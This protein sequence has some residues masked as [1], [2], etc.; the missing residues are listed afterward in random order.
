MNRMVVGLLF[1]CAAVVA[2]ASESTVAQ[3]QGLTAAEIVARNLAARGGQDA[4]QK[5]Q[6]MVWMGHIESTNPSVPKMPFVLEFKRPNKTRFEIRPQREQ[7]AGRVYDGEQGWKWRTSGGKPEMAPFTPEELKFAHDGQ[8]ID[9][10]LVGYTAKGIAVTLDGVDAVGGHKAYRLN[11]KLPSGASQQVWIDAETFLEL[12]YDRSSRNGAGQSAT[13]SMVYHDY[14]TIEGLKIPFAIESGADAAK[15]PERMAIDKVVLNPSLADHIFA[16]PIMPGA[17]NGVVVD[18][19]SPPPPVRGT[20][21]S[22][23]PIMPGSPRPQWPP[24]AAVAEK[25]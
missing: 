14:R 21:D 8:G 7:I 10:P 17:G 9:G 25:K 1:G 24:R 3:A 15:K 20:A 16:R 4:W 13:T 12:R 18:T 6:T 23:R 5:I 2:S 19:R 22:T 11:A